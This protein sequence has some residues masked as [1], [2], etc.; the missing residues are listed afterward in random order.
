M[1]KNMIKKNRRIETI[2]I[3][4]AITIFCVIKPGIGFSNIIITFTC[5]SHLSIS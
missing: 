2:D 5:N 3:A 4:K 1:T